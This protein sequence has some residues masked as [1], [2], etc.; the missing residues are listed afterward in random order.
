MLSWK[1]QRKDKKHRLQTYKTSINETEVPIAFRNYFL[2]YLKENIPIN[3][4]RAY[5]IRHEHK[6]FWKFVKKNKIKNFHQ[7]KS[8]QINW[9]K[10]MT[11][12][13]LN[14]DVKRKSRAFI[15]GFCEFCHQINKDFAPSKIVFYKNNSNIFKQKTKIIIQDLYGE[16]IELDFAIIP[17]KMNNQYLDYVNYRKMKGFV[18]KTIYGEHRVMQ[19]LSNFMFD[20]GLKH[21]EEFDFHIVTNYVN[22]VKTLKNHYTGEILSLRSQQ[23]IYHTNRSFIRY[24]ASIDDKYIK[25]LNHFE[26]FNITRSEE[27]S[28]ESINENILEQIKK[29]LKNCKDIYLKPMLILFMTY[30]LRRSEI[31]NLKI[32]CLQINENDSTKYDLKFKNTKSDKYRTI[33]NVNPNLIFPIKNLIEYTT[34]LREK[35]HL[36]YL[37]LTVNNSYKYLNKIDVLQ[38]GAVGKKIN[39]FIKEHNIKDLNGEYPSVS[40]HMFRRTIPEMYE[41]KGISLQTTQVILGHKNITTTNKHYNRTNEFEYEKTIKIALENMIYLNSPTKTEIKTS[42]P[43]LDAYKIIEEG[44]CKSNIVYTNNSICEHLQTRGNCYGCHQMI[45]TPEYLPFFKKQLN[46]WNE[47][48]KKYKFLGDHVTRHFKWKIKVV[49]GI[50]NKLEELQNDN[51]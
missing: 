17:I 33:Y 10:D 35:S 19:H 1:Y 50:I 8:N 51:C 36:N 11:D 46:V 23:F 47:E 21:I 34:P 26:E 3:P 31:L 48:I 15:Y 39:K 37:F 40:P 44:Y 20:N 14:N 42:F 30:G 27:L 7:L 5:Y 22:Y 38:A 16:Q 2:M 24:L 18:A 49:Q 28:T 45:T 43:N 9:E 6:W 29:E 4:L 32:D 13:Y 25:T 41:K 12:Y